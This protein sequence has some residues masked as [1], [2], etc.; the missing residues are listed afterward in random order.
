VAFG[1]AG[2]SMTGS[3]NGNLT[4]VISYLDDEDTPKKKAPATHYQQ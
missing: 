4:N 2:F 1:G 3:K